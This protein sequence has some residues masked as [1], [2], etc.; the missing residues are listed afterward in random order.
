MIEEGDPL[1][2]SLF[3]KYNKVQMPNLGVDA[4]GAILLMEFIERQSERENSKAASSRTEAQEPTADAPGKGG[5]SPH[6]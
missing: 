6:R 5:I 3:R 2:T 4:E 1:A